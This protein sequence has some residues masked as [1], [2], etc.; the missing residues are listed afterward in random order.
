MVSFSSRISPRTSTV[1]FFERSPPAT[2]VVTAA[3]FRTWAVRFPAM[4]FT[5]SVRSFRLPA[6]LPLGADFAR[7]ARHLGGERPELVDHRVDRVLQLQDLALHVHGD[8]LR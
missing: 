7:D 4:K 6:E 8:L 3:M 5:L 1:I 2:A